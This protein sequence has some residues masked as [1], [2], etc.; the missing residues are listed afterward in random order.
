MKYYNPSIFVLKITEFLMISMDFDESVKIH[1]NG[2]A[3]KLEVRDLG[4]KL[5]L[6]EWSVMRHP[7]PGP[8]GWLRSGL[9]RA[10]FPHRGLHRVLLSAVMTFVSICWQIVTRCWLYRQ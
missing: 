1:M 5:D 4:R 2:E 8:R 3:E 9:A 10:T 6:S 7:F